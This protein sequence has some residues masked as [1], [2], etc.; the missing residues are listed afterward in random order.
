MTRQIRFSF[1]G[2]G[3]GGAKLAV[4]EV[5]QLLGYGAVRQSFVGCSTSHMHAQESESNNQITTTSDINSTM[6]TGD[7]RGFKG[8]FALE[9][10]C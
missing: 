5:A 4:I 1:S 2:G 6:N 9:N 8:L 3:N 7:N 10:K